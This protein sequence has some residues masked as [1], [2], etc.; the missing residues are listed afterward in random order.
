MDGM[1]RV[2]KAHIEGRSVIQAVRFKKDAEPDFVGVDLD[3]LP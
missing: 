1:H 3:S 2:S